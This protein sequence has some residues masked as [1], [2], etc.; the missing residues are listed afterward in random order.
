VVEQVDKDVEQ[1]FVKPDFDNI[2]TL[3]HVVYRLVGA[4]SVYDKARN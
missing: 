2:D 3:L 4:S 1:H